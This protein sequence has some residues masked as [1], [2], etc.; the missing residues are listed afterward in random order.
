M[1]EGAPQLHDDV[2]A[3]WPSTGS[4]PTATPTPPCARRG[5]AEAALR[6][7]AAGAQRHGAARRRGQWIPGA[8][9]LTLWNTT[10]NPHIARFLLCRHP[11]HPGEQDARD[12]PRRGRR[13][14]QQDSLLSRRRAGDLRLARDGPPGQV[15]RGPPRELSW[16][17]S[18][19]ATRSSTWSWRPSATARSP[20]CASRTTPTWAP[21]SRPPRP[22]VPTW[23]F[24]LIVP[25]CYTI[26]DYACDV[27][28]VFTNTTP[29][30]A[31]RGAGRPE[32][33]Y[34]IER[35][36]DLLARELKHGP[37][38]GAAQELHPRGRLPLHQ[39]RHAR[40]TTAATTTAA[41][42]SAGDGGLP[43]ASGK[44]SSACA[45]AGPLPRHRP[46]HLRGGLRPGALE[47]GGRDGLPG[48][49]LGA[50]DC[51]RAA[52]RQGRTC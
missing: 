39:R 15:D 34:L 42:Q 18:T 51:A 1:A 49:T 10:Q 14:R 9:E 5:V 2:P 6:A 13:L 46:L 4:S 48:R 50:G 27:Y 16:R 29:T 32:A 3:I 47:G 36:V 20:A 19:G 12:R 11:R 26:Q 7:A 21:T 23:L 41:G 24:A 38:G 8:D 22:G 52:D 44:S 31:Y 25:G 45:T 17:R 35:M 33:A 30:D 28:G 37:G 40:S 43:D